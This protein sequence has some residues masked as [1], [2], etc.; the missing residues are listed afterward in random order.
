[1]NTPMSVQ[2]SAGRATLP[3]QS[4]RAAKAV[5]R[6]RGQASTGPA[7]DRQTRPVW[8]CKI[9]ERGMMRA[10]FVPPATIRMLRDVIRDRVDLVGER[11]REKNRGGE[12]P[13]GRPDQAAGCG[14]RIFGV[15]AGR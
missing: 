5:Q 9:A 10:S 2:G 4:C 14:Q 11:N 15:P 13:G 7:E 3:A 6:P 12:T 1:M 8:L